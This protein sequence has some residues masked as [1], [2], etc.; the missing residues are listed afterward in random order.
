MI[1]TALQPVFLRFCMG[2]LAV[3]ILPGSYYLCSAILY[4]RDY[5]KFAL[6]INVLTSVMNSLLLYV[7]VVLNH[8]GL[9]SLMMSTLISSGGFMI[10]LLWKIH[11]HSLVHYQ[12]LTWK[13]IIQSWQACCR[14]SL[15]VFISFMVTCVG[16]FSFNT[17]V[18]HF[19]EQAVAGFGIALRI[20]ALVILPAISFGI[21]TAI[22]YKRQSNEIVKAAIL[23]KSFIA[24]LKIYVLIAGFIFLSRLWWVQFLVKDMAIALVVEQYLFYISLSYCGFGSLLF[25]LVFLEQIGLGRLALWLNAVWFL[26]ELSIGAGISLYFNN[27]LGLFWVIAGGNAL[28]LPVSLFLLKKQ[29]KYEHSRIRA[30]A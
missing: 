14:I 26:I 24:I 12:K 5:Y 15:P 19:G 10:V 27:L 30:I 25:F 28:A 21:A 4:A 1:S 22:L 13:K 23:K 9:Y 20:Q 8:Q 29:V 2:M 17:I 3:G 7:L 18:L 6:V 16:F 11:T